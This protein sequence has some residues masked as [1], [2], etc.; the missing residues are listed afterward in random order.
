MNSLQVSTVLAGLAVS[1]VEVAVDWYRILL[2]R[3]PDARPTPPL[4]DWT[5][6]G[7]Y[8]LQVVLDPDLAG[9]STVTLQVADV[10]AARNDL[11]AR[12]IEVTVDD[13][14]SETVR[15]GQVIDPDGNSVTLVEPRPGSDSPDAAQDAR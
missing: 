11:A 13:T 10:Y 12:G 2:G 7:N 9:G 1:D 8:T 4:A 15:F 3:E 6:P 5:F 14:T